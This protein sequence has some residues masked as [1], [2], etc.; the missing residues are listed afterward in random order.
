MRASCSCRPSPVEVVGDRAHRLLRRRLAAEAGALQPGLG[1]EQVEVGLDD[2][3]VRELEGVLDHRH[4]AA[5]ARALAVEPQGLLGVLV[6]RLADAAD[7]VRQHAELLQDAVVRDR[8]QLRG[9]LELRLRPPGV[10]LA[11]QRARAGRVEQVDVE[12]AEQRRVAGVVDDGLVE[13]GDGG[14]ELVDVGLGRVERVG[15]LAALAQRVLEDAGDGGERPDRVQEVDVAVAALEA[16]LLPQGDAGRGEAAAA[17]GGVVVAQPVGEARRVGAAADALAVGVEDD[18][19]E[20]GEAVRAQEVGELEPDALD[21]DRGGGLAD[22][23]AGVREAGLD[24][25]PAAAAQVVAPGRHLRA[26]RR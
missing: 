14:E 1:V 25:D 12:E 13:L 8:A 26:P 19:L 17:L 11:Q 23:A 6:D 10:G 21:R 5:E 7:R 24:A 3:G 9:V 16:A 18:D 4:Q 20:L 2:V 15:L 22:V